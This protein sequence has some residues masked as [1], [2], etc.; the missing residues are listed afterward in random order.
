MTGPLLGFGDLGLEQDADSTFTEITVWGAM[1]KV[2][3]R[4]KAL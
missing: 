1:T 2:T 3:W 4:D